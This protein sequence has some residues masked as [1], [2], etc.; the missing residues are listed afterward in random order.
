[1]PHHRQVH[2]L[3]D[4]ALRGGLLGLAYQTQNI[5]D[6]LAVIR[7]LFS[8]TYMHADVGLHEYMRA[9]Q[10]T[11]GAALVADGSGSEKLDI[12]GRVRRNV[13]G[14]QWPFVENQRCLVD[15]GSCC[16]IRRQET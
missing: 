12:N 8:C 15:G 10:S 14:K 9:L 7:Q 6:Y 4:V 16:M 3:T 2:R 13:I 5:D 11:A 1:M